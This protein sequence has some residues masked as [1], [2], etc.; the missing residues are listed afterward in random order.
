MRIAIFFLFALNSVTG[1]SQVW[2]LDSCVSYALH[3]NLSVLQSQQN[4]KLSEINENVALGGMLPTLNAQGSH[5]YNWG[6]RI[7]PFTNQ[8]ASQRIQSNNFG[9]ATS[10]NLFNGFQQ[11]NTLKQSGLNTEV[12]KW[13]FEK[14]RN[15][16]A[17]NVA[18]AYLNVLI[19]REFEEIAK[20]TLESTDRQVNRMQKLVDA[21]QMSV[22]NLNELLAQQATNNASLV[23]AHNSTEL[24]K[25][26]LMQLLQLKTDQMQS[27]A[28]EIPE[29]EDIGSMDM[30]SNPDVL[31]QAAL[32]NFPEIKGAT[33][34]VA[35]ADIGKKI[36]AANYYPSLNAS[37]SYGTGYSGAAKVVTGNP[38]TLSYPIGT[39]VGTGDYVL[40][41]PQLMYSTD[42]YKTKAFN[43][44]LKD[45]VNKS[46]F[47]TLN[48]P[49]FNGFSTRSAVKRSEVNYQVA[50][51]QLEQ[52]K[53]T[54]TQNVYSAHADANAALANYYANKSSVTSSEKALEWA[55][56]R[57]EQ[58]L[59]N[60]VEY[61]DARTRLENA[62]ANMT[63]SKY[64]FIFKLKLLEF[65]QGKPISLK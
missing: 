47:F 48:I 3:N 56:L 29:I 46:L 19:N 59:S 6:Q 53:Q 25:L 18:T 4:I 32:N 57:Y 9:I 55:E 5:G 58:G 14:M 33:V 42:D 11:V 62:R 39:V 51:I 61:S 45:N 22:G 28:I 24:A 10:L 13:N 50:N 34:N 30:I 37:F 27:F 64:E 44:Q 35:S 38:D 15:D 7:D 40:S 12:S 17:L 1:F 8:F 16:I 36:A 20:R 54:I 43:D 65:Y 31:V 52:A 26:S 21:G 63:R 60:I 23:S 2:S 41:F 49:L